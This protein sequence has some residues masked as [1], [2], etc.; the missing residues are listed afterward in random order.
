MNNKFTLEELDVVARTIFG[1]ARGESRE[2]KIAVGWI[3]RNRV[4]ADLNNDNK[5]DWW[6]EGYIAVCKLPW[7]FSCWNANDPN[8][9]R[10]R[11]MSMD[12]LY[13]HSCMAAA[14]DVLMGNAGDP[15][16][17]ADHYFNP[18]VVSPPWA[19]GKTPTATIGRHVF[20]RL[21]A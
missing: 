11:E 17:S 2:G 8:S 5:P 10:I 3:I 18:A 19:K 16:G 14:F 1:E 20:Y 13:W 7:Q 4:E 12:R 15:T 6:G 9:A 21:R